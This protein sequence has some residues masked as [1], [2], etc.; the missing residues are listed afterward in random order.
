MRDV[1]NSHYSVR[2]QTEHRHYQHVYYYVERHLGADQCY[3]S[4]YSKSVARNDTGVGG[5]ARSVS[6]DADDNLPNSIRIYLPLPHKHKHNR[7]GPFIG[8]IWAC[9][10]TLWH[11]TES[12][13]P[14]PSSIMLVFEKKNRSLHDWSVPPKQFFASDH[15]NQAVFTVNTPEEESIRS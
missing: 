10:S 12:P 5:Q 13:Y 1:P 11:P 4:P 15:S 3:K 14:L 9:C 7:T 6:C 2:S 8:P